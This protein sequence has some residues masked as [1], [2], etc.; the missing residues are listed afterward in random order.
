MLANLFN[1]Q[2]SIMYICLST[3]LPSHALN[4]MYSYKYL[5]TFE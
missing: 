2:T 5:N 1:T 3:Y 4:K